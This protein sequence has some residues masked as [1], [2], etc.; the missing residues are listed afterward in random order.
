MVVMAKMQPAERAALGIAPLR[1]VVN[2][3]AR[4]RQLAEAFDD[5]RAEIAAKVA[6]AIQQQATAS[7]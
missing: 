5:K 1:V 4:A 6:A 2:D 3:C 7:A